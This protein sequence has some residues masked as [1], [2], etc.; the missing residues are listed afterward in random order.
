[1]KES[2]STSFL[3]LSDDLLH[4]R[5]I[6]RALPL[7]KD[8]HLKHAAHEAMT[9]VEQ[10]LRE[11]GFYDKS[12]FGRQLIK[13]AFGN[14][15]PVTLEVPL[16]SEF[17]QQAQAYFESVFSYYRNYTAHETNPIDRLVC[18]R[19][20]VIASELLDLIAASSIPYKGMQTVD[21]L[22]D[23]TLFENR[24]QFC[25]LLQFLDGQQ[26]PSEVFDGFFEDLAKS[27]FTDKQYES[28]FQLGL[29][30]YK[31]TDFQDQTPWGDV[32]DDKFG[33]IEATPLGQL[34][35]K[36]CLREANGA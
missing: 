27:G 4:L 24:G 3:F 18:A 32:F 25:R 14:K 36:D 2:P 28:M 11:K 7:F 35:L 23:S 1:M 31:S 22:V 30:V 6:D 20:M 21:S 26:F 13:Y 19:V 17:Q 33:W 10:A 9:Q 34:V 8:G 29:I 16:G 12:L 15:A 5:I